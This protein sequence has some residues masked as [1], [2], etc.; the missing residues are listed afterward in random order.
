MVCNVFAKIDD[1]LS[2]K[3][4]ETLRNTAANDLI[5][6]HFTFSMGLRNSFLWQD[7]DLTRY[8]R[9][10]GIEHPDIMSDILTRAYV[11]YLNGQKVDLPAMARAAFSPPPPP[12]PP[13][14]PAH[15]GR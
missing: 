6:F 15:R 10:I 1:S 9:S 7:N 12:E 13:G 3:D 2:Q 8:F 11:Q 4:K 14:W 5:K